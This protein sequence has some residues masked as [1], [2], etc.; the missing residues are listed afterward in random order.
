MVGN[1]KGV[2]SPYLLL[3]TTML[4]SFWLI[5]FATT[6]TIHMRWKDERDWYREQL[7]VQLALEEVRTVACTDYEEVRFVWDFYEVGFSSLKKETG[8]CGWSWNLYRDGNPTVRSGEIWY[9]AIN[10]L[11]SDLR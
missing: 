6:P 11:N 7:A 4:L 9:D 1:E 10:K 8:E 3:F 5:L 2:I